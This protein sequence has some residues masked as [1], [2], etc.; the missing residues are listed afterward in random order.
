MFVALLLCVLRQLCSH[1]PEWSFRFS[2]TLQYCNEARGRGPCHPP[3]I[4]RGTC[5][6]CRN[7][8]NPVNGSTPTTAMAGWQRGSEALLRTHF[9]PYFLSALSCPCVSLPPSPYALAVVLLSCRECIGSSHHDVGPGSGGLTR[10]QAAAA[11][12][13][14]QWRQL[15]IRRRATPPAR[16]HA[17]RLTIGA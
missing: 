7:G 3:E 12:R 1:C 14:A 9:R 2:M 5:S 8:G 4:S 16:P 15:P 11:T 17:S 13:F 10:P 6:G